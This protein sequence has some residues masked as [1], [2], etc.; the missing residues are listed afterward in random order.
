MVQKRL[1]DVGRLTDEDLTFEVV[2]SV[3]ARVD[4]SINVD[5]IFLKHVVIAI[6]APWHLIT[7]EKKL[8]VDDSKTLVMRARR[9]Y[10]RL[11]SDQ[12]NQDLRLHSTA[13]D[14]YVMSCRKF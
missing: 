11:R 7:Y 6:R 2:Q 5:G 9:Y 10:R 13:E 12:S 8:V 4:R 14:R 1:P 3:D